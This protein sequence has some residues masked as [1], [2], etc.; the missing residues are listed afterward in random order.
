VQRLVFELRRNMDDLW[1]HLEALDNKSSQLMK[2]LSAL[3]DANHLPPEE[4]QATTTQPTTTS[5]PVLLLEQ[6]KEHVP[7]QMD[8]TMQ[9]NQTLVV[10]EL[11]PPGETKFAALCMAPS[12]HY[13]PYR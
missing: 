3:Q 12:R 6:K 10:E 1:F 7:S 11:P 8:D 5:A 2:L 4:G 9:L 13:N